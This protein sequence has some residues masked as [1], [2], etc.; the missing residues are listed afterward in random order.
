MYSTSSDWTFF[1]VSHGWLSEL[2]KD[3][4]QELGA[5]KL[6]I[7]CDRDKDEPRRKKRLKA[8]K[9]RGKFRQAG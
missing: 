7:D 1:H 5:Q 9:K 3:D 2:K 6:V 8:R 4:N